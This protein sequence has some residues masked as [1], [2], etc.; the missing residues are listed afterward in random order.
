MSNEPFSNPLA[1]PSGSAL[2]KQ[3]KDTLATEKSQPLTNDDFRKLM[4]TPRTVMHNKS[5][6]SSSS[7]HGSVRGKHKTKAESNDN[8]KKKR[9]INEIIRKHDG[10][11]LNELNK[12]YRDRAKERRDGIAMDPN[13]GSELF[14]NTAYHAV[15]PD[16]FE[17]DAAE[18]RRQMIQESKYLGGDMEHTHL[19]KGLD[20]ALLQKIRAE[21]QSNEDN[22]DISEEQITKAKDDNDAEE[23]EML[24]KNQTNEETFNDRYAIKS[25]K[26]DIILKTIFNRNL[27]ERNELFIPGRL[28]YQYDLTNEFPENEAPTTIIRSKAECPSLDVY[29]PASTN[30]IILNKLIQIWSHIRQSADKR[31]KKKFESHRNA[32]LISEKSQEVV[33]SRKEDNIYEDIG[34]YVPEI[35]STNYKSN[36]R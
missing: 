30:E 20:Y 5:N 19:V 1:P 31:Q 35:R 6:A 29:N 21:I 13:K 2:S 4:M 33:A 15:G 12:K 17:I 27:P 26:A 23:E 22:E 28:A 34:D 25:K 8:F 10:D 3:F 16:N 9:K 36:K 11:I 24:D 7:V 18:R 32:K 14:S